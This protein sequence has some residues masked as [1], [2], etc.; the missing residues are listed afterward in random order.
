M[1]TAAPFWFNEPMTS[2]LIGITTFRQINRYSL[3]EIALPDS[4]VQ[5]IARAGGIPVMIPVGLPDDQL[6]GLASSLDGLLFSGGGDVEPQR[7]GVDATSKVNTVDPDRDRLEIKLVQNAVSAGLPFLGICRGLQVINVALGGTLHVDIADEI[8]M[9]RKHDY[10][11]DWP[12]DYLAHEVKI[13]HGSKLGSIL[14]MTQTH[15]NSLHHQAINR[16]ASQLDVVAYA[17]DGIVEGVEVPGHPFGLGVQWHPECLPDDEAMAA[18]FRAF[19]D[20]A[21]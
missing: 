5:A 7:Y 3:S 20:A 18:L 9:A 17:P 11:P 8:P 2:P 14:G 13:Q 19:V 10:Y 6:P 16:T 15:V 1:E 12:R 21:R 4:Y